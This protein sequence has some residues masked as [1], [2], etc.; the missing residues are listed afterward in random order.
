MIRKFSP[1]RTTLE[2]V[3]WDGRPETAEILESWS[4]HTIKCRVDER[5]HVFSK[6]TITNKEGPLSADVGDYIVRTHG[7]QYLPMTA[8]QFSESFEPLS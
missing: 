6:L 4:Y 8:K 7:G 2:A 5:D 3:R 1:R